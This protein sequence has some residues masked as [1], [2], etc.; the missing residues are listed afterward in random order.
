MS[1]E[2]DPARPRG[3]EVLV[4]G[5]ANPDLVLSGDV[6]PRFGQAEQILDD[7]TLVIGGSAAITAHGLARLGRPVALLAAVGDDVLGHALTNLL[8]GAGVHTDRVLVRRHLS[9]GLTVVLNRADDRAI[10]TSIGAIDTL[11]AA[12][13]LEAATELRPGGLRHVHVASYFL[14]PGL[15]RELPDVL[16]SLRELGLTTS[17]DTNDDPSGRWRG[18]AELL[19]HLDLLLPNRA[20]AVALGRDADVRRAAH[21]LAA[22]GPT[23]VVKDGDRGAFAVLPDG[24]VTEVRAAPVTPVDTTGAGDTFDAAFLA[25]WGDG[26]GIESAL[27]RA[28]VAGAL[29]VAHI[30]GTAGQPT[31]DQITE[32]LAGDLAPS[33]GHP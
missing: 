13:V 14:Q 33:G 7:A 8:A 22:H 18:I 4:V 10:L 5:D 9:T 2:P 24:S 19:P 21:A 1:T 6:V 31:P 30:G 17:L 16:R 29:S 12:E 3:V 23:T 11:T 26:V 27:G 32:A 15:A 20:E 28:V 25:A